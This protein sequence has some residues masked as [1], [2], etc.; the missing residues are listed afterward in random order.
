VSLQRVTD[1][2]DNERFLL[3]NEQ[4]IYEF[5]ADETFAALQVVIDQV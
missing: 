1:V 3:T 4:I 5:R 2:L